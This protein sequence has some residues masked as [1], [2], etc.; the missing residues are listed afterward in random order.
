MT[1]SE[2]VLYVENFLSPDQCDRLIELYEDSPVQHVGDENDVWSGRPKWLSY[3]QDIDD[4]LR[5]EQVSLS[6][7]HFNKKFAQD[8][9]HL[10]VWNVGHEMLPHSDY[11][12]GEYS[13]RDYASIV[14]LNDDYDGGILYMPE[15]NIEIVPKKGLFVSFR[16]GDIKHGVTKITRGKRYTAIC[17]LT[18]NQ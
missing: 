15:K 18:V 11:A 13:H 17:W 14:Y 8:N 7:S 1:S 10:M 16:G 4:K 9:L 3:P 12:E 5:R 2:E 6:E